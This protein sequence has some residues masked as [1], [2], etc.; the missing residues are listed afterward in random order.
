MAALYFLGFVIVF[1]RTVRAHADAF[2]LSGV[3]PFPDQ[4][5]LDKVRPES[6]MF[7]V[8]GGDLFLYAFDDL[9]RGGRLGTGKDDGELIAAEARD[10]VRLT[11]YDAEDAGHIDEDLVADVL[12]ERVVN[13]FEPV[14]NGHDDA[15]GKTAAFLHAGELGLEEEAVVH[16]CEDI[17]RAEEE[18]VVL[19]G[20]VL[21]VLY[22]LDDVLLDELRFAAHCL[23][24]GKEDDGN[25]EAD[26]RPHEDGKDG[27]ADRVVGYQR[28]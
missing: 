3:D 14:H 5:V 12:A 8:V 22:C 19:R 9:G 20:P 2:N 7:L 18:E 24:G 10:D 21:L 25:D 1:R 4:V 26:G 27:L 13:T 15:D 11:E 17:V 16:T 6:G 23:H 28:L